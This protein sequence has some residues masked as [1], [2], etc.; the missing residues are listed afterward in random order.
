MKRLP[1]SELEIM[2]I[3][4]KHGGA[5]NR[6]EIEAQLAKKVAAPTVLSFLNRLETKGFVRVEKAGKQNWYTPLVGEEEY[7]RGESRNILKKLYRN[8]VRNFMAAL[9]EGEGMSKEEINEL[10]AFLDEKA[11][12]A[13]EERKQPEGE[14]KTRQA[15]EGLKRAGVC[16]RPKSA[17][18]GSRPGKR[19]RRNGQKKTEDGKE[20]ADEGKVEKDPV[21]DPGAAAFALACAAFAG[22]R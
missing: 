3:L 22:Q 2:M 19:M 5:M 21:G 8:S 6:M 7:V 4:W 14:T 20:A 9:Y 13:E 11:R 1:E 12:Q 10:Q 17:R 16:G 18:T 15:K